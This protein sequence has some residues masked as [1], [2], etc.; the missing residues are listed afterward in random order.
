VIEQ[1]VQR[2]LI[3]KPPA[4]GPKRVIDEVGFGQL[5][6]ELLRLELPGDIERLT[7]M[8]GCLVVE[9]V[10]EGDPGAR[11]ECGGRLDL[12]RLPETAAA[13]GDAAIMLELTAAEE[14]RVSVFYALD[15][16]DLPLRRNVFRKQF[17][18]GRSRVFLFLDDSRTTGRLFVRTSSAVVLHA[19]EIRSSGAR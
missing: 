16:D 3:S 15:G 6:Q 2:W 14:G 11:I 1:F 10:D 17:P 8:E 9:Q 19:V 13:R 5:E 4:A 18:A 7:G 12:L